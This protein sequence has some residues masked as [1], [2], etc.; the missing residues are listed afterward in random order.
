MANKFNKHMN[1]L[2]FIR[3]T[4]LA[5]DAELFNTSIQDLKERNDELKPG[6]PAYIS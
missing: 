4:I 2:S 3:K 6:D 5:T 1:M